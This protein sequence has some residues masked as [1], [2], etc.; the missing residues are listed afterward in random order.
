MALNISVFDKYRTDTKEILAEQET[1][2][3]AGFVARIPGY[4]LADGEYRVL[5]SFVPKAGGKA[6][7]MDSGTVVKMKNEEITLKRETV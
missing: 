4:S 3:L 1:W 5:L 6:F 7:V 2:E